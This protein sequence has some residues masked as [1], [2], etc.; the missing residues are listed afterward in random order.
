MREEEVDGG[1]DQ[2]ELE[3]D[4]VQLGADV[5]GGGDHVEVV[6]GGSSSSMW[7]TCHGPVSWPRSIE[8]LLVLIIGRLF[9]SPPVCSL[10]GSGGLLLRTDWLEVSSLRSC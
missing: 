3:D 10:R 7:R 6:E 5:E 4:G 8:S 2:G 1:G 9:R